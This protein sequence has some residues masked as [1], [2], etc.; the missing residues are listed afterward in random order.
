M[1]EHLLRLILILQF[2]NQICNTV[3]ALF[4]L[5]VASCVLPERTVTLV[6][7]VHLDVNLYTWYVIHVTVE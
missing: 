2:S 7:S 6:P 5:S 4:N 1:I 3:T